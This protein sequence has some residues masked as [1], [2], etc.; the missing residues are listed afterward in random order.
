MRQGE[1]RR[2]FLVCVYHDGEQKILKQQS[3]NKTETQSRERKVW[4]GQEKA[5]VFLENGGTLE[6]IFFI[7]IFF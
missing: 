7:Y 3:T 6:A 5:L 4:G 1:K 2:F